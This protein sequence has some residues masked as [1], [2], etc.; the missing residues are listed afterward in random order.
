MTTKRAPEI[1]VEY[2]ADLANKSVTGYIP[3]FP[4]KVLY[5]LAPFVERKNI[6]KEVSQWTK[7]VDAL[8][9][10]YS[11]VA[12][13]INNRDNDASV[14]ANESE[15][16][17]N[18]Y[19]SIF[20]ARDESVSKII[21]LGEVIKDIT[22]PPRQ[23][24]EMIRTETINSEITISRAMLADAIIRLNNDGVAKDEKELR[25]IIAKAAFYS[26]EEMNTYAS[27]NY[28]TIT[29]TEKIVKY[30]KNM[31][32]SEVRNDTE[33]T[34]FSEVLSSGERRLEALEIQ[35]NRHTV[36]AR[37][38]LLDQAKIIPS[39]NSAQQVNDLVKIW[40]DNTSAA[41][42]SESVAKQLRQKNLIISQ[43]LN[44][45]LIEVCSTML[46]LPK[47]L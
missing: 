17:F 37:D 18:N 23:S 11:V 15:N 22:I 5:A 31:S 20:K 9:T 36:I 7:L 33:K 21:S 38:A 24:F 47:E 40:S 16:F 19:R 13:W 6:S 30:M 4:E 12:E 43:L 25:N 26:M 3:S 10:R 39:T 46:Q 28:S 34:E 35:F 32:V 44:G 27:P 29:H 2:L 14:V 41:A 1:Q 42:E 8:S 45:S